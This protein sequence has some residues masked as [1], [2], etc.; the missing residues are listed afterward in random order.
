[1]AGVVWSLMYGQLVL[2]KAFWQNSFE[3][4]GL[5]LQGW[6]ALPITSGLADQQFFAFC[7]AFFIPAVYVGTLLYSLSVF[8]FRRLPEYLFLSIV[9]VYGLGLYHYFI[10]RSGV[11]SFDAVIVPF[12][13]VLLGWGKII[14]PALEAPWQKAVKI[15]LTV[16]AL[17]ALM[18][19]Y[20]FTYYPNALNLAQ[21]PWAAE[22]DFYRR[23]FDFSQDAALIDRLT[24]PNEAVPL[25]SSFETR[26]L[27]QADRKPFFY[28][29]PMVESEHMQG[30]KL[31]DL[32]LHTYARLTRTIKQLEDEKPAHVFIQTRLIDGPQAQD[33]ANSHEAFKELMAYI[34]AH[35]HYEAQGQ[36]LTALKIK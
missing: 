31:R 29:F 27:M 1:V 24:A 28:Y 25:I 13:F 5:F 7:M 26:I 32:Y 35:Y 15:F 33:Y 17:I 12:I 2:H 30:A 4:A 23:D 11:T 8:I 6:G 21:V 22:E 3:F 36:Y 18:T 10:H 14:L 20:L 34:N 19:T 16:W 9:S